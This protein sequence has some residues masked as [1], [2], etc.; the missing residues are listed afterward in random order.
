MII[1]GEKI[2]GSIPSVARAIESRDEA[3]IRRLARRQAEAGAHYIDICASVD[4]DIEIETM[5]WLI[6]IVQDTVDTPICIDSPNPHTCVACIPYCNKEGIINSVSLEGDK[7]E[8]VFPAIANTGWQVVALLCDNHGIPSTVEKRLNIAERIFS[9]VNEYGIPESNVYI[10]PL[11][12][13]LATDEQSMTKFAACTRQLRELYP[14][15]HITSGLSNISFGLPA[16]KVI[17]SAFMVLAMH[18]GMDSAIVDPL[19]RDLL[20]LIYATEALTECDEYC[21]GFIKAYRQGIIGKPT[22]K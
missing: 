11:V 1:I 9:K 7:I 5:K 14:E 6:D 20:G 21:L 4:G 22:K 17:N 2:N 15:A 13:A 3:H 16:R 8:T 19:N 10:D 18:A 12:I